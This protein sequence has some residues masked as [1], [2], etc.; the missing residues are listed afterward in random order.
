MTSFL[1]TIIFIWNMIPSYYQSSSRKQLI[2]WLSLSLVACCPYADKQRLSPNVETLLLSGDFDGDAQQDTAYLIKKGPQYALI[3]ELSSTAPSTQT[4]IGLFNRVN[5]KN[6]G[7]KL[8]PKHSQIS[9]CK[10]DCEHKYTKK[11][12]FDSILFFERES[13]QSLFIYNPN[14]RHFDEFWLSD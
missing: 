6:S 7:I 14:T 5:I 9:V 1:N 12:E 11:L 3:G 13:S 10:S 4:M 8:I 2:G